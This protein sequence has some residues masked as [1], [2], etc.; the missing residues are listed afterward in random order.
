MIYHLDRP[1][2][3]RGRY[4]PTVVLIRGNPVQEIVHGHM[5]AHTEFKRNEIKL[6]LI[7]KCS[8]SVPKVEEGITGKSRHLIIWSTPRVID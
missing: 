8:V 3:A 4:V 7:L 5:T 1:R 6:V 2:G